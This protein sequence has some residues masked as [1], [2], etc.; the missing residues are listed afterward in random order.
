MTVKDRFKKYKKHLIMFFIY[1]IFIG[2]MGYHY[3]G[4]IGPILAIILFI[5]TIIVLLILPENK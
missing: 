5:I 3:R 2:L 4:L 1:S